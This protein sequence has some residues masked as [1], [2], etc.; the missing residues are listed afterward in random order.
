MY[1]GNTKSCRAII[2]IGI[3]WNIRTE[4]FDSIQ[5][6]CSNAGILSVTRNEFIVQLILNLN[7]TIAEFEQ[8]KLQSIYK[9]WHQ[10]DL[11]RNKKINIIQGDTLKKAIYKGINIEG[12]LNVEID[13]KRVAIAS[14]EVSIRETK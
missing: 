9:L 5:Q 13:N 2:G 1:S 14:G 4:L 6:P 11:Y 10:N 12:M 3:N 8:N 7:S